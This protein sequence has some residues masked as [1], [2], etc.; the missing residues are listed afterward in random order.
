[1]P[2]KLI[3]NLSIST[4]K[5]FEDKQLLT[6]IIDKGCKKVILSF[7]SVTGL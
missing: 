4:F 3:F 7:C 5:E 2:L 1:V 6:G